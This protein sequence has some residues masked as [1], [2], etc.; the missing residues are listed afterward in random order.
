MPY[1]DPSWR[2]WPQLRWISRT[3]CVFG[4]HHWLRSKGM[5]HLPVTCVVCQKKSEHYEEYVRRAKQK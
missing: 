1:V 5:N 4:S 2:M 3:L